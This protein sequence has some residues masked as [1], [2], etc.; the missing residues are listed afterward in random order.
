[1]L[2]VTVTLPVAGGKAPLLAIQLKGPAP[3]AD[4]ATLCPEQIEDT[5][6]VMATVAGEVI[7]TVAIAEFVQVPVP[8]ITVYVVVTVGVTVTFPV[9]G[10]NAPL[11]AIQ[12]KGPGPLADNAAL[13]PEQIDV[14]DGVIATVGAEVVLTVTTVELVQPPDVFVTV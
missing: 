4:K 1:M 12:L 9:A 13:C 3:L 8:E 14:K 10:G 11:L 5:D 7:E 6:G 2:G